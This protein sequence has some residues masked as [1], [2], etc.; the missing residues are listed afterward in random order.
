MIVAQAEMM[1]TCEWL[2]I[3]IRPFV[4]G[5]FFPLIFLLFFNF[6]VIYGV[7]SL[8]FTALHLFS[9][10]TILFYILTGLRTA[11][12]VDIDEATQ[13]SKEAIKQREY[14]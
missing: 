1:F 8:D 10:L 14:L 9:Y 2:P 4:S 5:L 3:W 6:N 12:A 11:G 7:A 13:K